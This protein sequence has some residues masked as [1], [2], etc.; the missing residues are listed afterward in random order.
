MA[1]QCVILAGG[2]GTRMR[3]LTETMPKALV[4]VLGVPFADWQLRHLS[5]QGVDRVVYSVG[6]RGEMLRDHVGDG[7]RFGVRV[8]WVDEGAQLR[9]T[10]G[11]LRLALD[12]GALNQAFFVLYGDS[13]LPASMA[14]VE[15]AWRASGAP[16]L[17][18]V[19]RNEGRWDTS[20]VVFADGRVVL[21]DK[22]SPADWRGDMRWIDY[23]LSILTRQ[24][25]ADDIAAGAQAD[26]ADLLRG[27]SR[28][29][30]LAG[31]EVAERFYEAGSAEGLRDLEAYLSAM[32]T[33]SG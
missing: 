5:S 18:T 16:A 28:A 27:L 19:M 10:G 1:L 7:S 15:R 14:E 31:H 32:H 26:L 8:T 11:A 33:R 9:G 6:Y 17:M 12:R 22:S 24:V 3:P 4:P 20:N 21:Y 2:L 30:K 25:I 23:G 29:G 13:Y